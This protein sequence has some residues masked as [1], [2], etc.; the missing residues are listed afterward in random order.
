VKKEREKAEKNVEEILNEY[1]V[2]KKLQ[3]ALN[4]EAE[5]MLMCDKYYA[6]PLKYIQVIYQ[7]LKNELK[8]KL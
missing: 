8:V 4:N 3:E 7:F 6:I 5:I 2:T 1:V